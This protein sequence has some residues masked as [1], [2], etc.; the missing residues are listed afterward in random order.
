[1]LEIETL[2]LAAIDRRIVTR[3]LP[4]V[5]QTPELGLAGSR[6][7]LARHA[8]GNQ[9]DLTDAPCSKVVEKV[10][11]I[12]EVPVVAE[13]TDV[14]DVGGHRGGV[15]VGSSEHAETRVLEAQAEPARAAE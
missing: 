5:N 14:G 6:K 8:A 1:M 12:R 4:G 10:L 15:E 2:T 13:A 3:A 11:G 7:R 9:V